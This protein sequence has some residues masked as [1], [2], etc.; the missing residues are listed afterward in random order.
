MKATDKNAL[1]ATDL[2]LTTLM[3]ELASIKGE[4]AAEDHGLL[5]LA[6]LLDAASSACFKLGRPG[7]LVPNDIFEP[8]ILQLPAQPHGTDDRRVA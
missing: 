1:L 4:N 7:Q 5:V 8:R 3:R 6:Q 2:E